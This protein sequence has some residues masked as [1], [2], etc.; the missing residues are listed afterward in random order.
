MYFCRFHQATGIPFTQM[1]F[2]DD[3]QRNVLSVSKIGEYEVQHFK[4]FLPFVSVVCNAERITF[5]KIHAFI[6]HLQRNLGL[7]LV[8]WSKWSVIVCRPK[9]LQSSQ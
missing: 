3:E 7:L 8:S 1:L 5:Y 4:M 6:I 2:F 9:E